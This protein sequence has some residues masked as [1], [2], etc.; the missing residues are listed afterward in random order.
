MLP[1]VMIFIVLAF[2]IITVNYRIN[3]LIYNYENI[4]T[5]LIDSLTGSA[6]ASRIMAGKTGEF[7]IQD[8]EHPSVMDK[9]FNE[10]Y[11]A[12]I[13]CIKKN[14]DLNDDYKT[15]KK[16]DINGELYIKEYCV[17]NYISIPEGFYICEIGVINGHSY[18]I[19]H[20]INE[21]V[22]VYANDKI[23]IIEKTSV[24]AKIEFNLHIYGCFSWLNNN[25]A[26]AGNKT[27]TL[28]RLVQIV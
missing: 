8:S 18:C 14:L 22:M 23:I 25:N 6:V 9:C 15:N 28:T 5:S 16:A 17:Y 27:Y 24:Y 3:L 20:G 7:I 21:N 4:E 1:I 11:E 2:F 12:F 13:R 10:S 19:E 26:G